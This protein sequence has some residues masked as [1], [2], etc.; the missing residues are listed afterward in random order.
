MKRSTMAWK[1]LPRSSAEMRSSSSGSS[2]RRTPTIAAQEEPLRALRIRLEGGRR[3]RARERGVAVQERGARSDSARR[4]AGRTRASSARPRRRA[5][6]RSGR[7]AGAGAPRRAAIR[8]PAAPARTL[9]GQRVAGVRG[10][11]ATG[12]QA[13]AVLAGHPLEVG[14]A[15]RARPAT[16]AAAS[17][18]ER[19]RQHRPGLAV[20][21]ARDAEL[22]RL[23]GGVDRDRELERLRV[24]A[25]P[26]AE[27]ATSPRRV[28]SSARSSSSN[29]A[30]WRGGGGNRRS[31]TPT[32]ATVA[33]P[34]WRTALASSSATPRTPK[35]P[36]RA[37]RTSAARSPSSAAVTASRKRSNGSASESVSSAARPSRASM[38]SAGVGDVRGQQGSQPAQVLPPAPALVAALQPRVEI[39]RRR[40]GARRCAARRS[41]SHGGGSSA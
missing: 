1:T 12:A 20:L 7:A 6:D 21:R 2:S 22:K 26:R 16:R 35:A 14:R 3:E 19:R 9:L 4:R 11:Q 31:A 5:R 29:S 24:A 28:F 15:H 34:R 23:V 33:N 8:P 17:E 38:T 13:P 27:G 36:A 40:R 32:I 39:G 10:R 41:D 25:R 30:S 37:S 18:Q